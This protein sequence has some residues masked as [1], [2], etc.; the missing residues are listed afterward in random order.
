MA[1]TVK[2]KVRA[3]AEIVSIM[4]T[5][6]S[7]SSLAFSLCVLYFCFVLIF[8]YLFCFGLGVFVSFL[9]FVK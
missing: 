1:K 4:Y 2:Q 5:C 3:L 9:A 6:I 8:V 7:L